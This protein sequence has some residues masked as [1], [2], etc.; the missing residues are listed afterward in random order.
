MSLLCSLIS[1]FLW[2]SLA[3]FVTVYVLSFL[4]VDDALV[5]WGPYTWLAHFIVVIVWAL[6]AYSFK[7]LALYFTSDH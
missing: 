5:G 2:L 3:L 7:R 4:F 1:K 6:M